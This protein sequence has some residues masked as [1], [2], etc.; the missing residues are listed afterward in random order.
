MLIKLGLLVALA[1]FIMGVYYYIQSAYVGWTDFTMKYGQNFLVKCKPEE[2][3]NIRFK[4]VVVTINSL[5]GEIKSANVTNILNG[6]VAAFEGN[7]DSSLK[8]K[9]ADPGLTPYTFSIQ[10]INDP[11]TIARIERETG[12]KEL[13]P[14]WDGTRD[15][16][17]SG[18][19]KLVN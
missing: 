17:M 2:V 19:M 6:M 13:E 5:D 3:A 7:T 1:M 9:L 15:I 16:I 12:L 14:Q 8:F 10:G 11:E 4:N 18:K